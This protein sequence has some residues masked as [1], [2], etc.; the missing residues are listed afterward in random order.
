MQQAFFFVD[1]IPRSQP[2]LMEHHGSHGDLRSLAGVN[3][4]L[5]LSGLPIEVNTQNRGLLHHCK[6][7]T[8]L[9]SITKSLC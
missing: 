5:R 4:M 1:L 9:I 6:S 2:S 3:D 7:N 8:S